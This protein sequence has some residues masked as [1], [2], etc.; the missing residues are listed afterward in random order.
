[1]SKIKSWLVSLPEE[2]K[3][4]FTPV[5]GSV[6]QFYTVVYLVAMNE[7]TTELDKPDQYQQRLH[8]IRH[9]RKQLE[10]LLDGYGLDGEG[11]VADIAGDYFEDY[12]NY[13]E[14]DLDITN[15]EF[16]R[17]LRNLPTSPS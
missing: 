1:M 13:R 2:T 8:T 7:H 14:P 4:L 9:I 10:R 15:E 17:I 16:M 12:V 6:E 3:A 11:T 5:F